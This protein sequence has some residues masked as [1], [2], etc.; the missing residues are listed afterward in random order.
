MNPQSTLTQPIGVQDLA[1]QSVAGG[2]MTVRGSATFRGE[3]VAR[4]VSERGA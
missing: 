4:L 1:E 2:R 3:R